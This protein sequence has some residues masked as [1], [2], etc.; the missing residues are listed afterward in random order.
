MTTS[1]YQVTGMSCAHCEAAIR[2]EV[3]RI[4]GVDSVAVSADTGRLVVASSSP[5]DTRAVLEAVDEAGY[6]AVLVAGEQ[7]AGE[8][9]S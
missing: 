6:E 4:P 5:V 1:E 3:S 8:G 7:V 2:M 9:T